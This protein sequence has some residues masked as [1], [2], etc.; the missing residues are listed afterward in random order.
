MK[1][2][3]ESKLKIFEMAKTAYVN[4]AEGKVVVKNGGQIEV[5][6]ANNT[7]ASKVAVVQENG[8]VVAQGFTTATSSGSSNVTLTQKTEAEVEEIAQEAINTAIES[9]VFAGV[10]ITKTGE[11][12]QLM[13]L[14]AFRDSVN[15]G[16][17][18]AGY[19]VK[20][21]NSF[22]IT[23]FFKKKAYG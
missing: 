16:N 14:E 7:D 17:S 15:A 11:A 5:V 12:T 3:F 1:D 18:Y 6:F 13:T 20:L 9:T 2:Y 4:V 8:G 10:A 21:L 19:T 22:S 23:E